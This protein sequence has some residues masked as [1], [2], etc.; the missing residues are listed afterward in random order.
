M[1]LTRIIKNKKLLNEKE[2]LREQKL[3][4]IYEPHFEGLSREEKLK[5]IVTGKIWMNHSKIFSKKEIY[6]PVLLKEV[7]AMK[8][9]LDEIKTKIQIEKIWKIFMISNTSQHCH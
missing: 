2:I 3:K 6:K 9:E 4:M 8:K 1:K 5:K 7:D